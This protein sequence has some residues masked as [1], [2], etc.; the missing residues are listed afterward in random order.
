[1]TTSGDTFDYVVVGGGS[2]GSVVAARLAQAGAD[3]LLLE[4][5]GSD[6]RIDVRIPA[7]VGIAYQKVNWKYPAEPDPTRTGNPEAW[8][9]G[10]VMG[11]GGSI[12]SC[13]FVRG[14]RADYDGWAKNGCTGWDYDSVL[15]AF[16]RMETWEGGPS[17]LRGGSGPIS[18]NVQTNR[19]QANMAYM[20]ACL[21]AGYPSNP[22]YNG[23]SQDGV[24][25]AQVNH[26]RGTRSQA[27]REYL[28]RVAPKGKVTVRTHSYVYRIVLEGN[29]A[30]AVQYRHQGTVTQARAREEV[31]ISA[32]SIGSPRLLQLS[33]I[34]PRSTLSDAAVETVMHLP[35]VGQ[36]L[37]EHPYLM[38]R[39]RSKIATINKM[40]I[41]TA[42]EGIVDYVRNGSG[43]LAMTM[44]QV[45]CMARTDPGLESPDLQ[46]Q[47]VPFAITRAVD[48]NGMFNVQK[49][50][51]QGFLSS[52]T[53]LRPRTRGSITLRGSAPDA[54]PRISYQFLADPDDLR[55]CVRGLREVQ[56]VMAQPAMAEIT[57]G[58]LE[59]EAD[60]RTDTDWQQYVRRTVTPSYH[61]V[62][63]CKMGIDDLAVVDPEL[64]V[65]GTANLRV[66]DASIMPT[67]TTGNTNAPSMMIGERAAELI[68]GARPNPNGVT[69]GSR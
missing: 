34:G 15:P 31:V 69:N 27:S 46:L 18:V 17:E 49:A 10:K 59:P 6:R 29:R 4:A 5:G 64:R 52:S 38:Q 65:H 58:Q 21:Q 45:Q 16:K 47:F 57:D 51:E 67:I 36:N 26:R 2:S 55:D 50:K 7:A 23:T 62:G 22:D 37:H 20:K 25:L 43:L 53:F 61:P 3:V 54:M 56:R 41:G 11:G 13:V 60:C 33:G 48:A 14:N 1:M 63:T 66:A 42:V 40:R 68:L 30:V 28:R 35:G 44:V 8:M 39:W 24:G 32:G 12:N 19:G 9:A